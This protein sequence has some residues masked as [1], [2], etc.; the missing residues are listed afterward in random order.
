MRPEDKTGLDVAEMMIMEQLVETLP[1]HIQIWVREHKPK[2]GKDAAVLADDYVDARKATTCDK[3]NSHSE[4]GKVK[5]DAGTKTE[6]QSNDRMKTQASLKCYNCSEIGHIAKKCPKK[7]GE[8]S[9]KTGLF[10]KQNQYVRKEPVT[11][12]CEGEV[13]GHPVEIFL[14]TGCNMCV[15]HKDLVKSE[16][17][18]DTNVTK[19]RCVHGDEKVYPTATV[20]VK[21]AD[22]KYQILAGVLPDLPK[23][24]L[25]G[26]DLPN[27]DQLLKTCVPCS[28]DALYMTRSRVKQLELE[29]KERL[30]KQSDSKVA[31]TPLEAIGDSD[32]LKEFGDLNVEELQNGQVKCRVQK[33]R[34]QKRKEKELWRTDNLSDK[35]CDLNWGVDNMKTMQENDPSLHKLHQLVQSSQESD[36]VHIVLK[37][38]ILFRLW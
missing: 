12:T 23:P 26:R 10:V 28:D 22:Q 7:Q 16:S 6:N 27:F 29:E 14:D 35:L 5:D 15:V 3:R 24:I 17:I 33:S 8:K 11:F 36:N 30:E 37:D 31:P 32:I 18:D 19:L 1:P 4:Q 21:I 13:E 38:G 9:G 34:R 2:S 20:E 25:I